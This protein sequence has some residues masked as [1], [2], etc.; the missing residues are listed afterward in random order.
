MSWDGVTER[1]KENRNKIDE[2][3]STIVTLNTLLTDDQTGALKRLNCV[4]ECINGNGHEGLKTSVSKLNQK[5]DDSVKGINAKISS[6]LKSVCVFAS[7]IMVVG[8]IVGFF[9]E[10]A[11]LKSTLQISVEQP[12]QAQSLQQVSRV[13]K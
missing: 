1:R 8:S 2:V 6:I 4:E 5:L 10:L 9:V 7:I 11:V 12:V 13:R 3:L